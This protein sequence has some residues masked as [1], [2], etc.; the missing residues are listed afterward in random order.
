MNGIVLLSH[1]TPSSLH[2]D[3]R[4]VQFSNNKR[5]TQLPQALQADK[6]LYQSKLLLQ[7]F[8]FSNCIKQCSVWIKIAEE[9]LSSFNEETAFFIKKIEEKL[10]AVNEVAV[11]FKPQLQQLLQLE[12]LPENNN[13]LQERIKK[14]AAWFNRQLQNLLQLILSSPAVTDSKQYAFTYN[15]EIKEL[16]TL[17]AQQNN[18]LAACCNG[19]AI[20]DFYKQKKNFKLPY[21]NENAYAGA[22]S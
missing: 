7:I 16:F 15:D 14:A 20:D 9:H 5:T 10:L 18:D 13:T 2:T 1:I 11:K 6:H 4:I 22:D 8:N 3:K 12:T 19:F 17:L 21:F